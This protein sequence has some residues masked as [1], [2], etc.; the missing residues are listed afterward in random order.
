MDGVADQLGL[1]WGLSRP[2][3]GRC[4]CC[5]GTQGCSIGHSHRQHSN[6]LSGNSCVLPMCTSRGGGGAACG[7]RDFEEEALGQYDEPGPSRGE[8]HPGRLHQ[9][10]PQATSAHALVCCV[11]LLQMVDSCGVCFPWI[12]R[13]DVLGLVSPA[14]KTLPSIY[15]VLPTLL[16]HSRLSYSPLC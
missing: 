16:Q 1:L 11:L 4:F 10:L 14:D 8:A 7:R 9:L 2:R 6:V 12:E 5:C 15:G 3:T 13:S